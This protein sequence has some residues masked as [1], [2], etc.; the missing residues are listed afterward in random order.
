MI[1]LPADIDVEVR[2]AV[3]RFWMTRYELLL[4]KLVRER[5]YDSACLLLSSRNSGES[6]EYE[7]PSTE[8]AFR[9]LLASLVSQA[10]A[11]TTA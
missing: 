6:G 5:L 11:I 2:K 4:T 1:S 7:E 9:R 8:L 3:Q 10:R